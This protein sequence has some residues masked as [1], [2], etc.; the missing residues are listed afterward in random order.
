MNKKQFAFNS[1]LI[2][3][4]YFLYCFEQIFG[5]HVRA[6]RP[7]AALIFEFAAPVAREHEG[8]AD[9]CVS[10]KLGVAEAVA[11]H[12]ATRQVETKVRRGAT[13]QTGLRLAAIA[14]EAI[15]RLADGRMVRAIVDCV[16]PRAAALQ[17]RG[18][19]FVNLAYQRLFK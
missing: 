8:R 9:S 7:R 11:D 14:V 1:S 3:Y 19:N 17:L 16:E 12:P 5:D 15:R 13:N 6:F 10:R 2:T 18:Q 4:H